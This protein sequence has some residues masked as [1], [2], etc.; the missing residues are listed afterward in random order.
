MIVIC[1]TL[2]ESLLVLHFRHL[3]ARNSTTVF[4]RVYFIREVLRSEVVKV[5]ERKY[6]VL[7]Q[8]SLG[9]SHVIP[10]LHFLLSLASITIWSPIFFIVVIEN[11]SLNYFYLSWECTSSINSLSNNSFLQSFLFF[12]CIR[13]KVGLR[14]QILIDRLLV[15]SYLGGGPSLLFFQIHYCS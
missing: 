15:I 5:V 7:L 11:F 2:I 12:S 9:V 13:D 8:L 3:V 1:E 10:S 6:P 4:N 14:K